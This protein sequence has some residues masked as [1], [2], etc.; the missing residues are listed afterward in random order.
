M[1]LDATTKIASIGVQVR[2][3][4]TMHGFAMSVTKEPLTW[5]DQVVT[6]GL[7]DVKAGCIESAT[8]KPVQV[9]DVAKGVVAA[10]GTIYERDMEKLDVESAGEV[11][12]AIMELEEEAA[13]EGEW[14]RHPAS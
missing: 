13:A 2:H 12:L 4:L 11:G 10:F 9:D 14:P 7:A 5:F 8:C 3:R 6:C 1:F